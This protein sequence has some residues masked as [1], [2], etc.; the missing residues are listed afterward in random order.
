[1]QQVVGPRDRASAAPRSWMRC[2]AV[3]PLEFV[4][5][6]GTGSL[7]LT[8]A[9][10]A[11]TELTAGSGFYAPTLF[12][13]YSSFTLRPAA[14]FALPVVRRPGAGVGHAARRRLPRVGPGATT[15]RAARSRTCPTGCELDSMEGAGE[16]QTPVTAPRPRRL[17]VGDRVYMRHAKA[18]E[19]CERFDIALPGRGRARSSTRCR[20]TAAK[21]A[22]SCSA[23]RASTA[24][25]RRSVLGTG[26]SPCDGADSRT[27]T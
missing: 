10:D 2:R 13:H 22:A 27:G 25:P 21:A 11:V 5:G 17:R 12:D 23:P 9:E 8:A 24:R 14:M 16:V 6:G 15:D 1:M 18:G 4:N 20:P 7:E 3:T 19:L 26:R